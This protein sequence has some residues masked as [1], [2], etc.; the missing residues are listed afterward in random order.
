MRILVMTVLAACASRGDSGKPADIP[1]LPPL[2]SSLDAP[3]AQPSG[4]PPEPKPPEVECKLERRVQCQAATP[5]RNP[6]Q[7][8][9]FESCPTEIKATDEGTLFAIGPA[10]FSAAETR[11][12]RHGNADACCYIA[13]LARACR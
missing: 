12:Q 1:P 13:F 6:Y 9:P 2:S 8:A 4:D 11:N 5:Q 7:G 3:A 10:K